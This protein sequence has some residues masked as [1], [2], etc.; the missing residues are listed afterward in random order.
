[1]L[2]RHALFPQVVLAI[3]DVYLE[4]IVGHVIECIG[5]VA[6]DRLLNTLIQMPLQLHRE[7]IEV[8]KRPVDIR[9]REVR[10]HPI[11]AV[12]HLAG[13]ALRIR[14]EDSY[15]HQKFED[16]AGRIIPPEPVR[17]LMILDE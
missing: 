14:A 4:E 9:Q 12:L 10:A 15:Q 2:L 7:I 11:E 17:F 13:G 16:V 5:K 3:G 6:T 8:V 1:M